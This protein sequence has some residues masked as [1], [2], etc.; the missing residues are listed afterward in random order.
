MVEVVSGVFIKG[1]FPLRPDSNVVRLQV[2][3]FI[4]TTKV[5]NFVWIPAGDPDVIHYRMICG[6]M[7]QVCSKTVNHLIISVVEYIV[8]YQIKTSDL[9]SGDN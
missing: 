2:M 3:N 8:K 6:V 9:G 5:D 4:L 7:M 1:C